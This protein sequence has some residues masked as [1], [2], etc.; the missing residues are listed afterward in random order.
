LHF[1]SYKFYYIYIIYIMLQSRYIHIYICFFL[2]Q[3][4]FSS[5]NLQHFEPNDYHCSGGV[6]FAGEPL[7]CKKVGR[8]FCIHTYNRTQ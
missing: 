7:P 4:E 3:G 8:C 5:W 1:M 6:L 2:F